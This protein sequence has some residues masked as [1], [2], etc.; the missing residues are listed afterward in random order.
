MSISHCSSLSFFFLTQNSLEFFSKLGREKEYEESYNAF[1]SRT[2]DRDFLTLSNEYC[3]SL[4]E[5]HPVVKL[6]KASCSQVRSEK[7]P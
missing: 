4:G 2:V 1:F 5:S 3:V 7:K 6:L